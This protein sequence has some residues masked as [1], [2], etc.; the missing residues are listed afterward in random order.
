[1]SRLNAEQAQSFPESSGRTSFLSLQN[2]KDF[3]IV[4]FAYNNVKEILDT[5]DLVHDVMYNGKNRQVDCLRHSYSEPTSVCP[6]CAAGTPVKKV[7]YFNVRNEQTG[8]M[9][10]WQRSESYF[11]KYMQQIFQE[12]EAQGT[13]LCSIPFKIIRNGVK[14]DTKTS[15]N[16]IALQADTTTLQDFPDDVDPRECG[17]IKEYNFNEL[18]GY[19]N[20]GTLPENNANANPAIQP[21]EANN[22]Y[23]NFGQP[24]RVENYQQPVQAQP[25]IQGQQFNQPVQNQ[26][27]VNN[28]R[29]TIMNNNNGGY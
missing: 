9:Q 8:E 21:R 2:D 18:Q 15:Y 26:A 6:L 28:N 20:N 14:G 13:P 29:R 16:L 10:L 4:R 1:M 23:Q 11:V 5:T 12:Y 3:A 25:A 24:A 17:I 27:P 19:V 22:N 7:I